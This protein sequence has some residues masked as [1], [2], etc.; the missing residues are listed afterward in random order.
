MRRKLAYALLALTTALLLLGTLTPLFS[1]PLARLPK[2]THVMLHA[3]AH[4]ALVFALLVARPDLSRVVTF[5]LSVALAA[6]L[7][8]AQTALLET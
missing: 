3:A 2:H 4:A 8:A 5:A 6:V 7:E 1:A